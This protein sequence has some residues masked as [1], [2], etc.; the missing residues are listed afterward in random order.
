VRDQILAE[1]RKLAEANGGQPLGWITFSKATGIRIHEWRGKYWSKWGDATRE[2]GF[3][4]NTPISAY[5]DDHFLRKLAEAARHFGAIP[6]TI[7]M[8]MYRR[9]DPTFPARQT[10]NVNFSS[11][12]EMLTQL[13]KW[14]SEHAEFADVAAMF[15]PEAESEAEEKA[16]RATDGYVY[17]IQWGDVYKIGRGQDLEKRVKQIRTGLPESGKLVHAIRTDDPSGIEAYWHRRFAD[18]RTEN[19]EWFRLSRADITAMRR[20]K[21]Q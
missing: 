8:A 2:A 4:P 13:R 17:L 16:A 15:P 3:E 12:A 18:K 5:T 7:Q 14:V 20:R 1:I 6:N 11:R 21:F 19:G 10:F 9:T